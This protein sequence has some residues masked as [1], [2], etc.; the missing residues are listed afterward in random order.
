M[1]ESIEPNVDKFEIGS[2][3]AKAAIMS[4]IANMSPE[5]AKSYLAARRK[6]IDEKHAEQLRIHQA[7]SYSLA[8]WIDALKDEPPGTTISD[9]EAQRIVPKGE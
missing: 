9:L 4:A 3:E 8:V 7:E 6:Y 5:E 2:P 1:N